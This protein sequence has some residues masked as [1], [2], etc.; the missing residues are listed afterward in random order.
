MP[1]HLGLQTR[2]SFLRDLSVSGAAVV[3][4]AKLCVS[5]L[6]ASDEAAAT[7]EQFFAL[8]A[9]THISESPDGVARGINMTDNLNSVVAQLGKLPIRPA[10]LIINGDCA[11]SKG[12]PGEYHNFGNCLKPLDELGIQVHL[13]M[14][15]HD[16][17][18]VLYEH[19]AAGRLESHPIPVKHVS[20]IESQF[21][22]W[23]LIDT[24]V[25]PGIALGEVG[26]DQLQWLTKELDARADKPAIVMAHH[27]PQLVKPEPGGHWMGI[28]DTDAFLEALQAR[29]HVRALFYGHTHDWSH[30]KLDDLQLVNL[31]A[32]SY[33]F[34]E[35]TPNGWVSARLDKEAM[36]LT[37]NTLDPEHAK[38]GQEVEILWS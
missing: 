6:V 20:I 7:D 24:L 22:N 29:K 9:D 15:N 2:R 32:V 16:D 23:F 37:L 30:R 36:H 19:F 17:R 35:N 18:D 14:G 25:R 5:E 28:W 21:A 12:T 1:L 11:L 4:S 8:L 10:N 3:V 26:V 34:N 31:P 33:V 13:T 38:A 27:N